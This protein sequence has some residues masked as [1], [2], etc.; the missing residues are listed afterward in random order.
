MNKKFYLR[1]KVYDKQSD[2][3]DSVILT[4]QLRRIDRAGKAAMQGFE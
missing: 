3:K 1:Y 4:S 2:V